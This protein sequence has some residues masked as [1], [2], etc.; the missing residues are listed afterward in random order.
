MDRSLFTGDLTIQSACAPQPDTRKMSR[1]VSTSAFLLRPVLALKD[2]PILVRFGNVYLITGGLIIS[3]SA[4]VSLLFADYLFLAAFP[5]EAGAQNWIWHIVVI[6]LCSLFFSKIFHYFALGK[7][8]FRNL[9][10]HLAETAFYNQ[11]GQLGV[12]AGTVWLSL[13]SG[14]NFFACMDLIITAGCLALALGR[15]GCYS[16]GC[17]HGRP[18]TSRLATVYTHPASK[19]LRI[20]PELSHV[21]L[22]PTQLYSAAF[23]FI[24]LFSIIFILTLGPK[25]GLVSAY[26]VIVYNIFRFFIERYRISVVRI[27][28]RKADTGIF[29]GTAISFIFFGALYLA[30]VLWIPSPHVS[31]VAPIG[32][33]EFFEKLFSEPYS[34]AA[35]IFILAVYI[36]TWALHYKKLGQHFEWQ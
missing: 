21:P 32:A 4:V 34:I 25:A 24:I 30:A 27:S 11:G 18:T 10:K 13:N 16:Y 23:N 26:F 12:L 14:I 1:L 17:C 2:Y 8:F 19:P 35:V 28:E 33:S 9:K 15:I 3:F 31:L 6:H 20:F 7:E 29:Q 5:A 22:V 36:A